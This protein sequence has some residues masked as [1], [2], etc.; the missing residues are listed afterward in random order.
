MK[1]ATKPIKQFVSLGFSALNQK[2]ELNNKSAPT[3]ATSKIGSW[4]GMLRG[5]QTVFLA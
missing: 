4:K 3:P 5:Y 1:K 2:Y